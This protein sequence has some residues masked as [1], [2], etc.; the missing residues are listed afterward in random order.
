MFLNLFDRTGRRHRSHGS[1]KYNK[2]DIHDRLLRCSLAVRQFTVR[3]S[4][5]SYKTVLSAIEM[6]TCLLQV[7]LDLA[8]YWHWIYRTPDTDFRVLFWIFLQT[9]SSKLSGSVNLQKQG[10]ARFWMSNSPR[11]ALTLWILATFWIRSPSKIKSLR[12][13]NTR[14]RHAFRIAMPVLFL[15]KSSITMQVCSNSTFKVFLRTPNLTTAL[16]HNF[17]ML[18]ISGS[19]NPGLG[20]LCYWWIVR[21]CSIENKSERTR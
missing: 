10:T 2:P 12:T 5:H 11:K 13:F 4:S 15:P 7:H 14:S 8:F 16:I 1:R 17:C 6:T 19:A 18:C 9:V 21:S 20:S 3:S